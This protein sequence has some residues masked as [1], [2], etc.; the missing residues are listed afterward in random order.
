MPLSHEALRKTR[1][2]NF[3]AFWFFDKTNTGKMIFFFKPKLK[4]NPIGIA[5]VSS[6]EFTTLSSRG[7]SSFGTYIRSRACNTNLAVL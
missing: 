2:E 3:F 6:A 4:P 1:T 5:K 7:R